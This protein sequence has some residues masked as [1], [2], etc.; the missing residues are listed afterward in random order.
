MSTTISSTAKAAARQKVNFE[1]YQY[2]SDRLRQNPKN[3][4][5]LTTEIAE[6]IPLV[7][8]RQIYKMIYPLV[9]YQCRPQLNYLAGKHIIEPL[10]ADNF[11][12]FR[13]PN[14]YSLL[15]MSYGYQ[16]VMDPKLNNPKEMP[17]EGPYQENEGAKKF[18]YSMFG[19]FA[20]EL[21][22]NHRDMLFTEKDI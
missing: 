11:K 21:T 8:E 22:S 16:F 13:S 5:G 9:Q 12:L 1:F 17:P 15:I 2:I 4:I 19:R 10:V 7:R 6:F 3:A 14:Q 18:R 20:K